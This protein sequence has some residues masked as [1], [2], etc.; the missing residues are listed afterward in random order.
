MNDRFT[1]TGVICSHSST[2]VERLPEGSTHYARLLCKDC[3]TFLR[4]LPKPENVEK[5]K[6]NGY[7]LAK[8]QMRDSLNQWERRFVQSLS[9]APGGKLTPKQQAVFDALYLQHCEGRAL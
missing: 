7:R 9:K 1:T 2:V 5:R 8:L 4:F 6:L 3:R